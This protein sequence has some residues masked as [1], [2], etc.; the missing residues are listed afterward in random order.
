MLKL[1]ILPDFRGADNA[2][3]GIRRVVEAQRKWLPE[4]D[5]DPT[6][7]LEEA[8]VLAC[9]AGLWADTDV[10]VVSH[11][12][13]LYWN[14]YDWPAWAINMNRLVID[15]MR[16]ADV[17]TAPSEWVG[18]I[19]R[20][21]MW[22]NPIVLHHGIDI[23][24]WVP[25]QNEGY[26]LWN[27][28]R[29]DPICDPAHLD[30]LAKRALH[31]TFVSTFGTPMPNVKITGKLP[32]YEGKE[33]I[34]RAGVYLCTSRETFGIGTLEAMASGV[35]VLAFNWGGQKEF[36]QHKVNGYLVAPYNYDALAEGLEYC[37]DHRRE[38]GAAGRELVA[39][40]FTWQVVMHKYAEV[41][42]ALHQFGH[43]TGPKVSVIIPNYKLERFLPDAVRSV[44]DQEN[45]DDFEI[46]VVNDC[47]PTWDSEVLPS[48]P[49]I[50]VLN[51]PKNL[52]LAGAL[53]YGIDHARG[54]YIFPLDA[55]NMMGSRTLRVLADALDQDKGIDI[56]YGRVQFVSESGEPAHEIGNDGISTWPPRQFDFRYQ[57]MHRNQIP[58]SSM[59]RRKV[60]QQ[61]GGY[62]TRCR[63]A[64]DADFWC[65]TTRL[66]FRPKH[67]TD[68]VTLIY[69][70][71]SDSMSRVEADWAWN[72]W[73][74]ESYD[75]KLTPF[76]V[77]GHH[78]N[79]PTYEPPLVSVVIPVGPGHEQ[80]VIDAVDSV[81]AQTFQKW[82]CIVVNDTDAPLVGLPPFVKVLGGGGGK[83]PSIA[84]NVGIKAST[85][86]TFLLLDADDYLQP[87][88]LDLM[89]QTYKQGATPSYV[90]SDWFAG[91]EVKHT[92]DYDCYALLQKMPHAVTA[93]YPR[94][95]W[96]A[97]GGF[98]ESIEAWEDWDF[99]IA[100][101]S[102]GYCGVRVPM[103]L[104]HYRLDSGFRREALYA[105]QDDLKEVV[106]QKWYEYIHGGKQLMACG[107]CGGASA[108]P[109][110]SARAQVSANGDMV[111]MEFLGEHMEPRTYRG[112]VSGTSYK[113]GNDSGHKMRYV[114]KSDAQGLLS[115]GV[116]KV[117]EVMNSVPAL[118][119]SGRSS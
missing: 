66:G 119:A 5:I 77:Q 78:V 95:A 4:Y 37:I 67:I 71:R 19:L 112:Q 15:A 113:F 109:P 40:Q 42:K 16:M 10:P 82:E 8:D 9:H 65:R 57:M 41:Y 50:R 107:S 52:Y 60:W 25:S 111:M 23:E 53:N 29:T 89:Y 32:F 64:E 91:D 98:D 110:M 1:C 22:L 85:A 49:C 2:D 79:V 51:T 28:T 97:V 117:Y 36:V 115:M 17:V 73:Y 68:A 38:L 100:I 55:D 54:K 31:R 69:R 92:A 24:D 74:P 35:P 116:F 59:Y 39:K 83:G 58:S 21:G 108:A 104:F 26:V 18:N 6:M 27:K 96:T 33:Y 103:P 43:H 87:N 86:H 72:A 63:T 90:Y 48:D 12:H 76:G 99:L 101:N 56:A 93:L 46:I 7:R 84:R 75:T 118:V 94:A 106:R 70:N 34:Q 14:E 62:R 47:S 80:V 61:S 11:C 114:Y 88:A 3:G 20:R 105:R 44:L 13:G 45:F 102:V 30:E 81:A